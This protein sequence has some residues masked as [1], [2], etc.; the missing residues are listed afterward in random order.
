MSTCQCRLQQDDVASKQRTSD[1][2]TAEATEDT[3]TRTPRRTPTLD[4]F[5]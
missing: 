5:Q 2:L 4:D 1:Y 3:P